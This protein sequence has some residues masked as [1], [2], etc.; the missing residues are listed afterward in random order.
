MLY[1]RDVSGE[2]WKAVRRHRGLRYLIWT[3]KTLSEVLCRGSKLP[4]RSAL[5]VNYMPWR[6]TKSSSVF[7]LSSQPFHILYRVCGLARLERNGIVFCDST[8][9]LTNMPSHLLL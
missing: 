1:R 7:F 4:C 8:Q 5:P 9:T 2:P 3:L 6:F